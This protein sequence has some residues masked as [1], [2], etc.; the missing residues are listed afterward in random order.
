MQVDTGCLIEINL[1]TTKHK[2][3]SDLHSIARN[4][5]EHQKMNIASS[6]VPAA[7]DYKPGGTLIVTQGNY[8]GRIIQSGGDNLGRWTY[9]T[10][11][12]KAG[13]NITIISAY[14]LCEQEI[15]EDSRVR[16]LTGTAQQTSIL[17]LQ[18]RDE[19]PRHAFIHDL[20]AFLQ[21]QRT[22]KNGI[23]LIGDFNEVLDATYDGI[24]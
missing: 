8:S 12:V 9:H 7:N 16:T 13:R 17:R 4:I 10:L 19:T 1:D 15:V 20:R 11:G 5:F 14:Q 23:F 6:P 2:I 24:T 3:T 21:E 22:L 18:V